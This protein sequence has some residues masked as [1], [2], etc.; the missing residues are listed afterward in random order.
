MSNDMI[1]KFFAEHSANHNAK[2]QYTQSCPY[3]EIIVR[4]QRPEIEERLVVRVLEFVKMLYSE[5]SEHKQ[6]AIADRVTQLVAR[7]ML[8]PDSYK[9]ERLSLA[10]LSTHPY[11]RR[12]SEIR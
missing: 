10:E 2:G 6:I 9:E 1:T 5:V 7:T 12:A 3:C 4:E 11:V 8:R